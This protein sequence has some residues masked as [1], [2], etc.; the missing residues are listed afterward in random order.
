MKKFTYKI[1]TQEFTDHI[2]DELFY[3]YCDNNNISYD[4]DDR[5]IK[6]IYANYKI[7]SFGKEGWELVSV[8]DKKENI[9]FYF[10]KE[11]V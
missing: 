3:E 7:N 10:K 8:I 6:D 11:I 5:P 1:I 9:T 4:S 2:G